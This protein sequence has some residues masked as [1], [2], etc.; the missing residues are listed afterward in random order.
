MDNTPIQNDEISLKELIIK[1]KEW[2]SYLLS[3]WKIIVLAG[4]IGAAL[5]LAYSFMKKPIYTATLSFALEDE[6]TGGGG[7]GS[8]LGL[9]SSFGLDLGGSG[10]GIFTGSNLTELFKSR[11]MV[12]KTLLSPVNLNGRKISLA[13]MY[14]ENNEWRDNWKKNPKL[15]NIQF[16][17]N[18]NRKYFT[19]IQDSIMGTIYGNLSKTG[20]YVG[21]K[22]K[23][24][25]IIDIDVSSTNEL[26]SKYFCEALAKEV[27]QF[28]VETKSKKARMNMTILERQVDSIRRELNGAITGVAV[29]NDN[30]FNLNPALNVRRAPSAR[31]QV[32]V[33]ANT[34]I[35][36]ELV[37]QS[38]L[39]KVTLRK[40]TPL[41]QVIDRPI[42]P[43]PKEKFGKAK[44]I[45]IGGI[46]TGFLAILF[47]LVK[48]IFNNL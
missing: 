46:L 29:A 11:S 43:L 10:G 13:E 24:V 5:G 17:P 8:A 48:R 28:Y 30:T 16:L 26:F 15:S 45:L 44:G 20:L 41:I 19:R 27:G 35:L 3:K 14:I 47:L 32:D 37:K 18:A 38:E 4:I 39:A 2:Y 1:I 6:K 23:K 7:L 22:D 42:L 33:Q 12:E 31:R 25:S 40:E 34:A 21:Q 36:T 9:A